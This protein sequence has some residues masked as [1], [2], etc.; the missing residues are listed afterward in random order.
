MVRLTTELF[1]DR[2]QFV[3][4]INM[5]EINLR[6]QKIPAIENMGVTRDQF[7]VIDFTD[8]DIRK[9]DNFPTFT[10]L[11]TLY[12][13]NNRIN[14]IAPDIATKLPN[15][16]TL[17]LTNNNL[18][19]LGDIEPLAECKKLEFVTFIGNPLTH[20]ENYRLYIIYKL[21]SVRVIDFNRVRMIERDSAKKMFKGKSGKKARDAIQ[22]SVHTEDPS[23]VEA[24]SGASSGGQKLTDEDRDKI[25][26]AI[27]NAKS[28]SEVNYLQSILASGKIPEK[29]WNRQMDLNSVEEAM[30]EA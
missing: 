8:N 2:P 4:S 5:R 25:K 24:S 27:R 21:P 20:K 11:D 26:E 29:G 6:G 19:E 10:R 7:D 22:K 3:N 23:E 16:K 12:L 18:C 1:A 28:L 17:A 30:M 13:H 15:L 14:Y 9:L